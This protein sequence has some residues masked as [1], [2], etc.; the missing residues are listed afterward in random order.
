MTTPEEKI[1][2][3]GAWAYYKKTQDMGLVK[4]GYDQFRVMFDYCFSQR[5]LPARVLPAEHQIKL[6]ALVFSDWVDSDWPKTGRYE[7]A[8]FCV[9]QIMITAAQGEYP[10]LITLEEALAS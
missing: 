9:K 10:G 1:M 7:D 4:N 5:T 8:M 3:T 2:T 6:A